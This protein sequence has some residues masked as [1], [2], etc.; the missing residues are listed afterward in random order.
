FGI[1]VAYSDKDEKSTISKMKSSKAI[2]VL[3]SLPNLIC[4]IIFVLYCCYILYRCYTSK[5]L[6]DK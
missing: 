3:M 2:S 4:Q 5:C 1:D 6:L